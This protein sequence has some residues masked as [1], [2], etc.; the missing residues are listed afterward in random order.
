M[1]FVFLGVALLALVALVV[2][3]IRAL[4]GRVPRRRVEEF[5]KLHDLMVTANNGNQVIAYRATTR[6][7]R[8][9]GLMVSLVVQ[10]MVAN[11]FSVTVTWVLA[12]WFAGAI[13][14]ELRV[15]HLARGERAA[16]SLVPRKSADYLPLAGR[17][18]VPGALA[19]CGVVAVGAFAFDR[20]GSV[21]FGALGLWTALGFAMGLATL[22]A[23]RR[24][25][26]RPQ[27]PAEADRIAAD[28]AIRSRS[29]HVLAGSGM[30]LV[31][32]CVLGQ[33]HASQTTA[34]HSLPVIVLFVVGG[35]IA[36][37]VLAYWPWS[38]KRAA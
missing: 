16:A 22:A 38:P 20:S 28:D 34:N 36:G 31:L 21:S 26:R 18:A 2:A 30:V 5:A 9:F 1:T 6:R 8:W 14:A 13:V 3:S 32:Y 24:V 7:W 25:L 17:W 15:A 27:P 19:V 10:L 37:R 23:Q 35:P 12:G 33:I 4:R 11:S 29:L